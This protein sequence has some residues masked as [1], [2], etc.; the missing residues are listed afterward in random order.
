MIKWVKGEMVINLKYF[1]AKK[2]VLYLGFFLALRLIQID[3]KH[4]FLDRIQ[5]CFDALEKR[6]VRTSLNLYQDQR[7]ALYPF[8]RKF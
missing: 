3:I 4:L 2:V 8:K 6:Y 5:G 1:K 7:L